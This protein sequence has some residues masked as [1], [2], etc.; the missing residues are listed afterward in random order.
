MSKEK[1]KLI[2][3]MPIGFPPKTLRWINPI[4]VAY[5][6]EHRNHCL[7]HMSNGDEIEYTDG[8]IDDLYHTLTGRILPKLEE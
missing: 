7:I 5:I 8:T 4:Q 2:E 6:D 1:R 3:F